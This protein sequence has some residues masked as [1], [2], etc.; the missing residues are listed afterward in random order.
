VTQLAPATAM[1]VSEIDDIFAG[2]FTG[3]KVQTEEAATSKNSVPVGGKKKKKKS[4]K[5]EEAQESAF[6]KKNKS[7]KSKDFS[8]S[9]TEDTKPES[10]KRKRSP[11]QQVVDS[12][13]PAKRRKSEQSVA[14]SSKMKSGKHD[15]KFRDSRGGSGSEHLEF[16]THPAVLHLTGKRTEEG[17]LIYT[18]EELGLSKEG[19]GGMHPSLLPRARSNTCA[20]P[21]HTLVSV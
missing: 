2:K 3:K 19:G 10:K 21:R 4:K 5:T 12:S 15:I 20:F 11:P 1:P 14:T 17:F 8:E 6:S 18:E 7:S 13:L 9:V 16:N